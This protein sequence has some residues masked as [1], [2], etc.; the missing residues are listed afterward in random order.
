[1]TT[2]RVGASGTCPS[3]HM[4]VLSGPIVL[5]SWYGRSSTYAT[6]VNEAIVLTTS[7]VA[8]V[9]IEDR[10]PVVTRANP[11]LP[12]H[13]RAAVVELRGG[14]GGSLLGI[15]AP[16]PFPRSHFAAFDAKGRLLKQSR[17]VGLPL[18]FLEPSRSWAGA[19][20]PSFGA[21][22][23]GVRG[24]PG[25]QYR[26][27]SVMTK[28]RSHKNIRGRE[29]IDCVQAAY[30]LENW[31]LE[32]NVLLDAAHPGSAPPG[33]PAMRPIVG[34]PGIFEWSGGTVA[35]VGRRISGAWLLVSK[36]KTLRQRLLLLDHIRAAFRG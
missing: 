35:M 14:S 24:L 3:F 29:F 12:D 20:V 27:G 32:V 10:S 7:E 11:L 34:H 1:V 9:A 15:T 6:P 18:E 8:S 16:P 19:A 31:P 22:D 21:C 33:L 36:G 2:L 25:L 4:P 5:E 23:Y 28:V 26:G 13:M 30:L 17:A